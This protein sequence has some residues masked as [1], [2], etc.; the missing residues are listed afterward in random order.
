M[1]FVLS[2]VVPVEY[3]HIWQSWRCS[4]CEEAGS[5][6][7]ARP[8]LLQGVLHSAKCS[9]T[10]S[11]LS[12]RRLLHALIVITLL[13]SSRVKNFEQEGSGERRA[14]NRHGQLCGEVPVEDENIK[15]WIN[16]SD[17]EEFLDRAAC[18]AQDPTSPPDPTLFQTASIII[19]D[20]VFCSNDLEFVLFIARICL[21]LGCFNLVLSKDKAHK[22]FFLVKSTN[23]P[24]PAGGGRPLGCNFQMEET[25]IGG[26]Q[27]WAHS[28]AHL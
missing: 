14:G 6:G 24:S 10:G 28:R 17:V 19:T 1:H 2:K 23:H 21:I 18:A 15:G 13:D 7:R 4:W 11:P 26:I 22:R 9:P 16:W 20:L 27:R 5:G 25:I 3:I 12:P 8:S